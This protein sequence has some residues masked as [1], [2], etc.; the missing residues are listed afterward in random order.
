MGG[1]PRARVCCI[2]LKVVEV[3]PISS[4]SDDNC[5]VGQCCVQCVELCYPQLTSCDGPRFRSRT[6]REVGC[7]GDVPTTIFESCERSFMSVKRMMYCPAFAN[8][9]N[10]HASNHIAKFDCCRSFFGGLI[11]FDL[12]HGQC[13]GHVLYN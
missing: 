7:V 6:L 13:L 2:P 4:S 5:Q 3:A 9:A 11:D 1:V 8:D 10:F 12:N